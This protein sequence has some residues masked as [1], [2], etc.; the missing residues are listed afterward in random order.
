M[1]FLRKIFGGPAEDQLS[2]EELAAKEAQ[3]QE[4]NFQ[5]LRDDG[6][7]AMH[8]G[9]FPFAQK[10]FDAALAI[11]TD[12]LQTLAYKAEVLFRMGKDRKS[13]V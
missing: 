11:H 7:R 13:V 4:R 3:Q 8:M 12:D 10:C 1:S 9:E 5:T 6:V 2:P